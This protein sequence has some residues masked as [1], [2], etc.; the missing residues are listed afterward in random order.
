MEKIQV[1][2]KDECPVA[3]APRVTVY[4]RG[5]PDSRVIYAIAVAPEQNA[6]ELAPVFTRMLQSLRVNDAS[7]HRVSTT[8]ALRP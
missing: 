4:T 8:S 1:P 5:L 7:A 3:P 2:K 6:D